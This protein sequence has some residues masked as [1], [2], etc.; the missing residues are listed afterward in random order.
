MLHSRF[1]KLSGYMRTPGSR[2]DSIFAFAALLLVNGK[3]WTGDPQKP[4]AQAMII[5]GTRIAAVG[6]NEEMRKLTGQNVAIYDLLN[7]RVVP[8]FNDAHVHFLEGG[9][10]LAGPQ[11]RLA[12]T[13]EEFRDTLGA[14]ART[15]PKGRWITHAQWDNE[16]WSDK[17]F[18]A[19]GL[20]DDA[21]QKWPVF[22]ERMD[23]H[24]ALANAVALAKAGVDK[25][26]KDVPGGVIVRDAE[27]NPTGL[28]KDAA[29]TLITKIVPPPTNEE[30]RAAVRAAQTYASAQGVTSVQD[31]STT[32]ETLRVYQAMLGEREL[33]VRIATHVPLKE[34]R[35]LG[36]LGVTADFGNEWI[37]IGA[38][39]GFADGS[40][41]S[42]T[43]LFQK[44]YTDD[45]KNVGIPSDELANRKQMYDNMRAADAAFLQIAVHA[46]GDQA[47]H[48]I[49]DLYERLEQQQGM[50]DRR[51]RIEHAQHLRPSD[52]RRFADL[53]VIASMQPY[54]CIDDGRWAEIHIGPER[55]K[56]AYAFRSL[57]DAGAILAFGSDW[58]VVPMS[59]LLG[60][61]AA[62]TRQT[63]DGKHPDGWIPA[64]KI[65]VEDAVR[66]YTRGSAM[67]S[68][69]ED[70]KGTLTAGKVADFA[71]LSDDIFTMDPAKIRNVQ[72]E[73]TVMGGRL[74]AGN[75]PRNRD[76]SGLL[77]R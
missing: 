68:F 49:L 77:L 35:R 51:L 6:T 26:T 19:H 76:A 48:E 30:V 37:T 4:E 2:L 21:T 46:I 43:A 18:P 59:P 65:T 55:A 1:G 8:G 58:P 66:A 33:K 15:Q 36:E 41:G 45:P 10:L 32:P 56:T 5:A 75:L 16:N 61:Y 44:P 72:V 20:I 12:K 71:V 57:L 17:S 11:T 73:A 23:G 52:I 27:G 39:K 31:M 7:R 34:W 25:N 13:P 14:Y 9:Q 70:L 3:I 29:Q 69:E 53:H 24:M 38:V 28:L 60:I 47:N 67:A 63:L 22:V 40:L 42:R 74:T 54:Q 50:R 62:V 64:Q